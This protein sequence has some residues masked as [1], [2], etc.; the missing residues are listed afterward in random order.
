MPRRFAFQAC[1][2]FG[3]A[4]R[5][6]KHQRPKTGTRPGWPQDRLRRPF[7]LRPSALACHHPRRLPDRRDIGPA[8]PDPPADHRQSQQPALAFCALRAWPSAQPGLIG[9]TSPFGLRALRACK[10][11]AGQPANPRAWRMGGPMQIGSTPAR[12]LFKRL[13]AQDM[14]AR[15]AGLRFSGPFLGPLKGICIEKYTFR[16]RPSGDGLAAHFG[17]RPARPSGLQWTYGADAPLRGS[18]TIT[19]S[20]PTARTLRNSA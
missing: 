8:A 14:R 2:P 13:V 7:G 19:V 4:G 20:T 10:T 3:L 9:R 16:R 1:A 11:G 15:R 17:L 6:A 12:P 5:P 18:S